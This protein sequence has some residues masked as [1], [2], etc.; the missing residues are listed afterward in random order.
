VTTKGTVVS[1]ALCSPSRTKI[2]LQRVQDGQRPR[3]ACE[4]PGYKSLMQG[5][6]WFDS[7]NIP[8][9]YSMTNYFEFSDDVKG[10]FSRLLCSRRLPVLEGV[11]LRCVLESLADLCSPVA[12]PACHKQEG[13]M[14]TGHAETNLHENAR[15]DKI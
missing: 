6:H 14:L 5:I 7:Q 4:P 3:A 15:N 9:I 1:G 8:Y 10:E 11:R 2:C 12:G 13:T